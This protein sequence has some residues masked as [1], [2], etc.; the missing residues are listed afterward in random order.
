V[1]LAS[2]GPGDQGTIGVNT[3]DRV[4]TIL[5]DLAV[6]VHVLVHVQER[7]GYR[8]RRAGW[9]LDE[10]AAGEIHFRNII[11]M[12]RTRT[13]TMVLIVMTS[14]TTSKWPCISVLVVGP[15]L[16]RLRALLDDV[17]VHEQEVAEV[18]GLVRVLGGHLGL[19][20]RVGDDHREKGSERAAR[21]LAELGHRLVG[22]DVLGGAD[23]LLDEVLRDVLDTRER[24]ADLGQ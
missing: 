14:T 6:P 1:G 19:A 9:V 13:M 5:L 21:E 18:D 22:H 10:L 17:L 11:K 16:E 15:V 24:L 4:R 8:L 23:L 3:D 7:R 2:T 12:G 20:N